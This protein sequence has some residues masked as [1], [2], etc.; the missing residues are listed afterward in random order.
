[1]STS[2]KKTKKMSKKTTNDEDPPIIRK[3]TE[4]IETVIEES[5]DE[6]NITESE[7]LSRDSTIP[8]STELEIDM[9]RA[10]DEN[11]TRALASKDR[12]LSDPRFKTVYNG[13]KQLVVGKQFSVQQFTILVPL[14]MQ[15]LS[16]IKSLTGPQKK[17]ML[18][19]VFRYLVEELEFEDIDQERLSQH[20]VENDLEVL[21]DTAYAASKG[22][23]QF[24]DETLDETY[25]M[26]KFNMVYENIK[27]M[28]VNEKIDIKTIIIL[29]PSVMV[30]AARFV[31][32]TGL[33]K[34][35]LV[36]QVIAKLIE[37]YKPTNDTHA[38]IKLF[39]VKQ[40]PTIIEIIYQAAKSKYIFKKI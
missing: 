27:R 23:F 36:T 11:R 38:I 15:L 1:M 26:E 37:E 20:F 18:I 19:K 3:R 5:S 35:E 22:K 13:V 29:V 12:D 17:A 14:A 28:I 9:N 4:T 10:R 8:H 40:L 25:D 2:K 24:K 6:S 16:D 34:K 32:L 7:L 30:Q 39:L 21:I 31:N 33:Q